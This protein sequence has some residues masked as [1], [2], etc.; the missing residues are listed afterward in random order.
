MNKPDMRGWRQNLLV[1]A[2]LLTTIGLSIIHK[3]GLLAAHPQAWVVL[4]AIV[5][6]IGGLAIKLAERDKDGD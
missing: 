1:L 5:T 6:A 3:D 4:M 2:A